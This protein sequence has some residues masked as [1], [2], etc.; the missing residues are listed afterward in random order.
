MHFCT[1]CGNMYYIRLIGE[2]EDTLVYYCRKCGHENDTT[3]ASLENIS[4]DG[5]SLLDADH[6][7][8]IVR[9]SH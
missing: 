9:L 2:N 5:A 1:V 7:C 8:H 3:I 4:L 6:W